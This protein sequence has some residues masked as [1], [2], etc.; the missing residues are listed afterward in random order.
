MTLKS[1]LFILPLF[2]LILTSCNFPNAIKGSKEIVEFEVPIKDLSEIAASG[3]YDVQIIQGLEETAT[4]RCNAN[5]KEFLNVYQEG[6]KLY[7]KMENMSAISN[8]IIDATITVKDLSKISSSG[9]S[10]VV[11]DQ[12][13]FNDLMLD[14]SG[15]SKIKANE[16]SVNNLDISA[17]GAA[18]GRLEGQVNTLTT[19]FNGASKLKAKGLSIEKNA[20]INASGASNISLTLNCDFVVTLSGAS[21]LR[22]Y[23]NGAI[24]EQNISGVSKVRKK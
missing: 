19:D 13:S 14:L 4:F 9:A 1:I 3:I 15:A 10:N 20:N 2:F 17:S 8:I 18:S 5:V 7:L 16:L 12:A 23:G 21:E 22:H 11:L 24:L 6:Q